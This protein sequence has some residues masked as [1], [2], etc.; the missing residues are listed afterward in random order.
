VTPETPSSPQR[1]RWLRNPYQD[2]RSR[3]LHVLTKATSFTAL[4]LAISIGEWAWTR[5]KATLFAVAILAGASGVVLYVLSLVAEHIYADERLKALQEAD[6]D[7]L[8]GLAE[9]MGGDC[10]ESVLELL[11]TEESPWVVTWM[12]INMA[13]WFGWTVASFAARTGWRW[14]AGRIR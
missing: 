13:F 12:L 5:K 2:W 3:G 6:G 14:L 9:E 11:T 8:L 10:I 7:S 4:A 1:P